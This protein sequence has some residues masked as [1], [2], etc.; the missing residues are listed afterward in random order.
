MIHFLNFL[1]FKISSL[2]NHN[3]P[4]FVCKEN[5]KYTVVYFHIYNIRSYK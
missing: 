3:I 2:Y 1:E 4:I 5:L